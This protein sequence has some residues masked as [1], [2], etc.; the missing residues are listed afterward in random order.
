[1]SE[2][3]INAIIDVTMDKLRTMVDA[4]T[5]LGTPVTVGDN[6][7]IPI[8]KV[9]FGLAPG[10]TDFPSKSEKTSFG[11]G[12]GAG[13]TITPIGIIAMSSGNVKFIPVNNEVTT[14]DRAL[15]ALPEIIDKLK[16]IIDDATSSR[17]IPEIKDL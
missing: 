12:G 9:S 5:I 10:G 7:V 11:G 6:T 16:A 3:N 4:D 13:V 15:Q 1:M 8:S 17:K 2:N 14:L